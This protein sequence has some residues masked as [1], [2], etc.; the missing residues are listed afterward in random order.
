MTQ[1][2]L[3]PA[4]LIQD[5]ASLK[6]LAKQL[7]GTTLL[8]V[9]TESNSLYAYQEQICL[10][11]L[12]TRRKDYILDPLAITDMQPLG[13][14]LANPKIEKVFHSATYDV[15]CL[16]RQYGFEIQTVF[17][18]MTAARLCSL[19]E[20]GLAHVLHHYFDV[21]LD[22]SHQTDNWM[23]RPLSEEKLRYAQMDTHY[24]PRLRD[25]FYKQLQQHNCLD[26]AHEVFADIMLTEI[27]MREFDADGYWK[28]ALPE[29]LT[30]P[31]IAILREVYLLRE[32]IAQAENLP[33]FKIF[34][35]GVLVTL[36]RLQPT[37]SYALSHISGLSPASIRLYGEAI[38][39]AIAQG[40][41]APLPNAPRLERQ[42]KLLAERY[43]MLHAWRR[44]RAEKRHIDSAVI[45][46]KH[47]LWE[48]AKLAPKT[49]EDLAKV[50]GLGAWRLATYGT[51]L[52]QITTKWRKK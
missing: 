46:S 28:I 45:M 29:N 49:L 22:K 42:P 30:R 17:D 21:Q 38:L 6:H 15:I 2:P 48:I 50:P 12:S 5:S 10:I 24:L 1:A 39:A 51:E 37:S 43:A 26:E 16:R 20:I 34:T 40:K 44:E 23:L 27:P 41:D 19:P 7:A 25:I 52:L 31:Q 18:T 9:D 11:Q 35:N 14:L 32:K 3:P 33:P 13:D 47:T 4:V 36:A 8:A